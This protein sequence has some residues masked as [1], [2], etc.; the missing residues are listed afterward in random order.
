[1]ISAIFTIVI[2]SLV[3][4]FHCSAIN[5]IHSIPSLSPSQ[6]DFEYSLNALIN[7]LLM[8]YEDHNSLKVAELY[9]YEI[10]LKQTLS[11]WEV[12]FDE[13]Y[14]FESSFSLQFWQMDLDLDKGLLI[15]E[16]LL[17]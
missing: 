1:M 6:S 13:M 10:I 5:C 14:L 2:A 8:A 7:L 9:I 12:A 11:G 17:S 3:I 4:V 16:L 15:D